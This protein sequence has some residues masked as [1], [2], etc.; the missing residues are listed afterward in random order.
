M[1]G[2]AV[3]RIKIIA[4]ILF[5]GLVLEVGFV[6]REVDAMSALRS[7]GRAAVAAAKAVGRAVMAV[8]KA[9]LAIF[10]MIKVSFEKSSYMDRKFKVVTP[11]SLD[12]SSF[13]FGIEYDFG[14]ER[15]GDIEKPFY[16]VV[17]MLS[18]TFKIIV[19][20]GA[21]PIVLGVTASAAVVRIEK[22]FNS[23]K[24]VN[25]F[26]PKTTWKLLKN[27]TRLQADTVFMIKVYSLLNSARNTADPITWD[28][29]PGEMVVLL[30]RLA[31]TPN[32]SETI[33]AMVRASVA[34]EWSEAKT[35]EA[36]KAIRL[37]AAQL[38]RK[39]KNPKY[40]NKALVRLYHQTGIKEFFSKLPK[41]IRR[42]L[43]KTKVV[44]RAREIR[45]FLDRRRQAVPT[46]IQKAYSEMRLFREY[47][48]KTV[49]AEYNLL[50]L[51]T[52]NIKYTDAELFIKAL[53]IHAARRYE[54]MAAAL[55]GTILP[56]TPGTN[57]EGLAVAGGVQVGAP[58][59]TESD[60]DPDKLLGEVSAAKTIAK[61]RLPGLIQL[62][63]DALNKMKQVNTFQ[64]EQ[65]DFIQTLITKISDEKAELVKLLKHIVESDI[66]EE[67]LGAFAAEEDFGNFEFSGDS[68]FGGFEGMGDD[69]T[70]I[71]EIEPSPELDVR[72]GA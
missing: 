62:L 27:M 69:A 39:F 38:R 42:M 1:D 65:V 20:E 7:A 26:I 22:L 45:E 13:D 34:K 8:G 6:P 59:E 70:G 12:D 18:P 64:K 35:A 67:E 29:V 46:T 15:G 24:Y 17:A 63:Q 4:G 47:H 40:W 51:V 66:S 5:V 72:E 25:K 33:K 2:T 14:F 28:D 11:V 71:G 41:L 30:T 16:P 48:Q 61:S 9:I 10:R 60:V 57:K 21:P 53:R 32:T 43:E 3:S 68:G 56:T 55:G 31:N 37:K 44:I 23:I 19:G 52:K 49:Y 36:R 50:P 54:G 58:E